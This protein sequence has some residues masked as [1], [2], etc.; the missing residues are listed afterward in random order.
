MN[1]QPTAYKLASLGFGMPARSYGKH[2]SVTYF[3]IDQTKAIVLWP[4]SQ[5]VRFAVRPFGRTSWSDLHTGVLPDEQAFDRLMI[6][7]AFILP[8]Q[9][10]AA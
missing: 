3:N 5:E 7:E 8:E 2:S 6:V 1:Y 10:K 4:G 9:L